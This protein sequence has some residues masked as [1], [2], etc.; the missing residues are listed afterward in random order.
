MLNPSSHVRVCT[1]VEDDDED[2]I[3]N[4]HP[5]SLTGYRTWSG[6]LDSASVC[7]T[8]PYHTGLG[9][10]TSDINHCV[11]VSSRQLS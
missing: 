9:T 10:A 1:G 5:T 4:I 3:N 7:A 6:S 11:G 2:M 8:Y